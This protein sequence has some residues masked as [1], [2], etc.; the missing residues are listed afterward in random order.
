MSRYSVLIATVYLLVYTFLPFSPLSKGLFILMFSLS[1]LVVIYMVY[2]VLK[3]GKSPSQTFD[4]QFYTDADFKP[5][6]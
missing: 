6:K 4:D 5:G 2:N 1:P 3:F